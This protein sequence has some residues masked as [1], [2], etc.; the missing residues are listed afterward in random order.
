MSEYFENMY[1]YLNQDNNYPSNYGKFSA[2]INHHSTVTDLQYTDIG[3]D[4]FAHVLDGNNYFKV[5]K[6]S[7]N[8]YLTLEFLSGGQYGLKIDGTGIYKTTSGS[9]G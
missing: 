1:I 2:V 8:N 7:G 5:Q 6:E 9:S 3:T 4:G